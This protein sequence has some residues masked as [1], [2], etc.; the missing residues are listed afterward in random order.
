SL[1]VDASPRVPASLVHYVQRTKER[2][3]LSDA[4]HHA[5]KFAG[6]D[7]FARRR[8]KSVLC[9]P[10]L[11][12]AEVVGLL[13]LE[14]D[15]LAGAFTPDRLAARDVLA[16]QAAISLDNARLLAKEQAARAAAED[17]E[18]RSAFLAEAGVL[19]SESLDYAESLGRLGRLCVRSLAD[20]CMIDIVEGSEIRR[21][22]G[23][24][25]DPAK[26]PM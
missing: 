24:H 9:L 11:R 1:S 19:L 25:A 21:I 6:D 15:L 4:A 18:R 5:G 16:T 23:T 12:Q 2:V 8:P 14:N 7:Y 20:H 22:A 17:A 10:I 3:I 13:Y 26:E